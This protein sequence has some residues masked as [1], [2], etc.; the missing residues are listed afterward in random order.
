MTKKITAILLVIICLVSA[1][2]LV[3]AA[4]SAESYYPPEELMCISYRGDT[5]LYEANSK[6]AVLSAFSK[7][8]DFVS[9]NVRKTQDGTFV[10][11]SE[12][13]EETAGLPLTEMFSLLNDNQVLI[14][15]FDIELKDEIYDLLRN[16]NALG[17][18]WL[19]IKDSASEIN[20]WLSNKTDVSVIGVTSSFNIF[21]VRS[22]VQK[23]YHL[24][25]VQL[26]N[27]N[28]F[29]VMYGSLCYSLY[30]SRVGTRAVAPMYDPDMCGQRSDS[31]D[32][33]N[34]LIKKNFSIIETNNIESLVAYKEHSRQLKVN[35]D[36]V[37]KRAKQINPDA[38]SLVSRENL[39]DAIE[40]AETLI[41]GGLASND[42]LENA[43]SMLQR[44]INNLTFSHGEDTQKGALNV[45]AGKVIAAVIM[46]IIILS[47]QIYTYKMQKRKKKI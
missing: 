23:L 36:T 22:F 14:L 25:A 30:D 33:W 27:K 32:G 4:E 31:E 43:A 1:F 40:N 6:E 8:A 5:A 42:E 10:L 37:L 11:C 18:A 21:T 16:E 7:G 28:Y 44:A 47:A 38:Y 24:P 26:Q 9:V 39:T 17:K 45:T 34:D 3:S 2:S 19:R 12:N 46:G 15:D 35:L 20:E 29:N 41:K 13:S